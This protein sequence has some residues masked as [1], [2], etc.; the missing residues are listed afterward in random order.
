MK[1][2]PSDGLFQLIICFDLQDVGF[3]ICFDT[4]IDM[5]DPALLQICIGMWVMSGHR[6][7]PAK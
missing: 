4:Q 1:V 3:K 7:P 6:S 2:A 5:L